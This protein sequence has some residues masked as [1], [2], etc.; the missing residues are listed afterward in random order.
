MNSA[1]STNDKKNDY[2]IDSKNHWFEMFYDD[3]YRGTMF[4]PL[5]NNPNSAMNSWGNSD[6]KID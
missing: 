4:I 6:L 2:N 3:I 1:L 5:N